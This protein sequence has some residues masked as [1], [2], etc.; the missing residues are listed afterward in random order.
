MIFMGFVH[1]NLKKNEVKN[2]F[3]EF[4]RQNRR[5]IFSIIFWRQIFIFVIVIYNYY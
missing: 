4:W 3:Y 2:L 5:L 1:I